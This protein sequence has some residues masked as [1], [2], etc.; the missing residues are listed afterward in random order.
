MPPSGSRYLEDMG[1]TLATCTSHMSWLRCKAG[2]LQQGT[3]SQFLTKGTYK[4]KDTE[5]AAGPASVVGS[6]V[7]TK[8]V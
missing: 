7:S 4:K 6:E 8:N 5:G 2:I 1:K 3:L